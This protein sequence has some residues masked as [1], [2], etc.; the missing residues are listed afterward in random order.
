MKISYYGYSLEHKVKQETHLV[1]LSKVILSFAEFDNPDVK[2]SFRFNSEYVYLKRISGCVCIL[3]MT[4]DGDQLRSIN[5][6]NLSIN[7]LTSMLGSEQ[8]L[9]FAS[10]VIVKPNYFGFASSSLSPKFDTFVDLVNEILS[11]TNNGNIH[12]RVTPLLRQTTK[13]E[14]V[15]MQYIGRTTIEVGRKNS[16]AR[17]LANA[18]SV[19]DSYDELDSIEITIKPKRRKSIKPFVEA[20]LNLTSEEELKKLNLKAKNDA[21]S[22]MLDL[23]VAGRGVISDVIDATEES[24]IGI[25]IE[26]KIAKNETLH[27]QLREFKRDGRENQ[28]DFSSILRYCDEPSWSDYALSVQDSYNLRQ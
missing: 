9:G 24:L 20:I 11:R 2:G 8:K 15:S 27:E 17:H 23:Y 25:N 22:A 1:D 26:E 12:F 13:N 4:R 10:Y 14:A 16:L 19:S 18:L 5:T 21:A 7:E 3:L 6:S 28:A